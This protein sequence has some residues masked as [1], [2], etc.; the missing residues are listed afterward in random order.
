MIYS[1]EV[2]VEALL[3]GR[4]DRAEG[5]FS[6]IRLEEPVPADRPLRALRELADEV[7]AGLNRRFAALYSGMSRPSIVPEM[8]LR[9]G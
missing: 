2:R 6:Y 3:R 5:I 1:A 8:L 4:D 9:V 7:P